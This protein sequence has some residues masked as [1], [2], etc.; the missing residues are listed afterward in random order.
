[1]S[2]SQELN[3]FLSTLSENKNATVKG[4]FEI[5]GLIQVLLLHGWYQVDESQI[6]IRERTKHDMISL[7]H[8]YFTYKGKRR[9][10]IE[11]KERPQRFLAIDHNLSELWYASERSTLLH[12]ECYLHYHLMTFV[13]KPTLLPVHV[14]TIYYI[15]S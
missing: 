4:E 6:D 10:S 9:R 3:L 13:Q 8:S 5:K 7:P 15:I 2:T 11:V 14:W 12:F 1:M